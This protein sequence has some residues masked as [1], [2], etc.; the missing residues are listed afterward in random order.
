MEQK[1]T[2]ALKKNSM[3][4]LGIVVLVYAFI[5]AGAF[6][7]EEAIASSGPGVTRAM[8]LIFP[9]V[10]SIPLG[11]MVAEL[12][13]LYPTEGG[14][15]SW[16]REAF[17][18]FWGWQVGLWSALT[19]WLCQAE[20]CA[21]VAGYLGKILPMSPEVEFGV[22]IAMVLIFTAI[23]IAGL[24]WM[25]K[26]ETVLIGLVLIAFAA[27]TVVGIDGKPCTPEEVEAAF[28]ARRAVWTPKKFERRGV[29]KYLDIR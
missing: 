14:I 24:D 18:E 11:E 13:S 10:W 23:N 3:S 6:G 19:T 4:L 1:S 22:K 17:G 5:A 20:Y 28:A 27:V 15:Y 2:K 12:G 9:F 8:L 29:L 16:A 25:E 21:L 26:I 7:I